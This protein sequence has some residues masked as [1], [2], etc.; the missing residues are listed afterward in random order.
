MSGIE[1]LVYRIARFRYLVALSVVAGM[2]LVW[3]SPKAPTVVSELMRQRE[4]GPVV[5]ADEMYAAKGDD[6]TICDIGFGIF[7]APYHLQRLSHLRQ[8]W[9]RGL[10]GPAH[11]EG[12]Y[13][14][15]AHNTPATNFRLVSSV[16][17]AVTQE[18]DMGCSEQY[19]NLCCK[20]ARLIDQ[21]RKWMPDKKWYIKCDDDTHVV[22]E[23][24][25]AFLAT[26]DP[27]VPI[28]VGGE[29]YT[30][31]DSAGKAI[32]WGQKPIRGPMAGVNLSSNFQF[33]RGG[34]GYV[35]SRALMDLLE[36]NVHLYDSVCSHLVAEDMSMG[37]VVS[38]LGA[39]VVTHVGFNFKSPDKAF[40]Q[41]SV[42]LNTMPVAWHMLQDSKT[43][44]D[45][46]VM[47]PLQHFHNTKAHAA[48]WASLTGYVENELLSASETEFNYKNLVGNPQDDQ[49]L[50]YLGMSESLLL[51]TYAKVL[52]DVQRVIVVGLPNREHLNSNSASQKH[53]TGL[54]SYY[55]ELK[56]L[57][58]LHIDIEH[59][60][61][62][63]EVTKP[64]W[65]GALEQG[66][67]NQ[68][69][70]AVVVH[71]RGGDCSLDH[72]EEDAYL[73]YLNLAIPSGFGDKMRVVFFPQSASPQ[74]SAP[75]RKRGLAHQFANPSLRLPV[76][77]S[78]TAREKKTLLHFQAVFTNTTV[79]SRQPI[80]LLPDPSFALAGVLRSMAL[81]HAENYVKGG[82]GGGGWQKYRVMFLH[83]DE[84]VNPNATFNTQQFTELVI[85]RN[86]VQETAIVNWD[87]ERGDY[88][89]TLKAYDNDAVIKDFEKVL[90][91]I[92]EAKVIVTDSP[93]AHHFLTII[94]KPHIILGENA[95]VVS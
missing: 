36:A 85:L 58:L 45:T 88:G 43:P 93:E 66:R 28:L 65:L 83:S 60:F 1:R 38:R 31:F 4:P 14:T 23:H 86:M 46:S 87:A 12:R 5:S 89:F 42:Y 72:K 44:H 62:D 53:M 49:F 82:D 18:V 95:T 34:A 48:D 78:L 35:M 29:T 68:S 8:S 37:V 74:E 27:D 75:L 79:D 32:K 61:Y 81:A 55:G 54:L 30:V 20:T 67:M 57:S 41:D 90:H 47:G 33:A 19:E 80:R 69:T 63:R 94:G 59:V 52:K 91:R 9:I 13:Y 21:F 6:L 92:S 51:E 84:A 16:N 10:C 24:L 50:E 2:S 77:I 25:V 73:N 71:S 40:A 3:L 11:S 22:T 39:R 56:L 70:A 26:L 7:H 64:E 17:D 15:Y 76:N